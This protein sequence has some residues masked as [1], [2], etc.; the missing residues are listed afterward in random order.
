MFKRIGKLPSGKRF[1]RIKNSVN[2]KDGKFQ[3]VEPTSINP[4][5]VSFFTIMKEMINR[6]KTV[7]PSEELPHTKT[8]PF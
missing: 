1:E 6:P 3:N 2:Y 5:N 7:T 8:K 4:N